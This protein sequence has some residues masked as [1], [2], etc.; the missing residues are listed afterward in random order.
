MEV[1][2]QHL[3][4]RRGG[5]EVVFVAVDGCRTFIPKAVAVKEDV[6]NGVAITAVWTGGIVSSICMEMG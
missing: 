1:F 6:V 4:T 3:A 5:E 2:D